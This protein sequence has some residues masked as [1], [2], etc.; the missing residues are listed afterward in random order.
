MPGWRPE[1]PW[2]L[3]RFLA[4][5]T[6]CCLACIP[7]EPPS[8]S[9]A[10]SSRGVRHS[11]ER[12]NQASGPLGRRPYV[13]RAPRISLAGR[14][15]NRRSRYP[16][17]VMRLSAIPGVTV[18]GNSWLPRCA[19]G[20]CRTM[21]G[22]KLPTNKESYFVSG[23]CWRTPYNQS[24]GWGAGDRKF[25]SLRPPASV[26]AVAGFFLL[27]TARAARRPI[28]GRR[29]A[30]PLFAQRAVAPVKYKVDPRKAP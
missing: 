5:R 10:A 6:R 29:G 16:F 19:I 12:C 3:S 27:L 28:A 8:L 17:S 2:G 26:K 23:S 15:A 22:G 4:R 1:R 9:G 18:P 24:P 25:K 30:C 14:S 7:R 21:K 11:G 13:S 20:T